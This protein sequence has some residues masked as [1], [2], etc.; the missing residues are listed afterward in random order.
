MPLYDYE[1]KT[2][3]NVEEHYAKISE[4]TRE[5][6]CGGEMKRLITTNFSA[7]SDLEPYLDPHIGKEPVWITS[8]KHRQQVMKR[9]G[10]YE[11][12]GKGW[13]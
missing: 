7:V 1:C 13:I 12:V 5:C 2:C 6:G 3:K 4:I 9:E 8:R 11:L 10:V